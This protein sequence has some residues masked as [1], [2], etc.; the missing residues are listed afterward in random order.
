MS[1]R[2]PDDDEDAGFSDAFRAL[3]EQPVVV[4]LYEREHLVVGAQLHGDVLD[5]PGQNAVPVEIPPSLARRIHTA[6]DRSRIRQGGG[7]HARHGRARR[8]VGHATNLPRLS[9]PKK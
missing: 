9:G 7:A 4:R 6:A 2:R 5:L 1:T 8:H 3:T